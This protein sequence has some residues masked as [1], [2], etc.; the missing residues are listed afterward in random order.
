MRRCCI[1]IA[2][3]VF[4]W[5]SVADAQQNAKVEFLCDND[6]ALA[7]M[8]SDLLQARQDVLRGKSA[9]A[10][11]SARAPHAVR[12]GRL[13][14]LIGTTGVSEELLE[15][16][17]EAKIDVMDTVTAFGLNTLIVQCRDPRQL[18]SLARR[19]DVRVITP[20]PLAR[21]RA[22]LATSQAYTSVHADQAFADFGVDGSGVRVGVLSDS[23]F[24]TRSGTVIIGFLAGCL[25]Q[26]SGDLPASI[27]IIDPGP[28]FDTIDEGNGMAQL[29][30]DLAPG[31]E[32]SFGSA[33]TDYLS[34][35]ENIIALATDSLAPADVLVDDVI[36]FGEPMYQ[37]GPIAIAARTAATVYGVP[38]FSSA[39]NEGDD[40]HEAAFVD[41]NSGADD[42]DFPASGNDLHDFGTAKGLASDTHLEI[43][44]PSGGY[45]YA[46]LHWTEPYGGGLA[47]GPGAA[48]DLDLYL[49]DDTSL[50]LTD[51]GNVVTGSV[52][53]Q[54]TSAA[55]PGGD[56]YELLQYFNLSGSAE[57]VYVVVDHYGGRETDLDLNLVLIVDGTI[58]DSQLVGDRTIYGH[59][60]AENVIAVAANRYDQ[61]TVESFS[62]LGGDLPFWFSDDG[63]TRYATAQTRFKPEITAPDGT[64][65]TF[66]GS[67]DFD[68]TGYPNFFGTS[69]AAPHAAAVA[70]LMLDANS[71]LTPA[72]IYST[73]RST[74]DDIETA[75]E[76]FLSGSGIV[77]ARNAVDAARSVGVT[78][79]DFWSYR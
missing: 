26:T 22:G 78:G 31:C 67:G 54:G 76:D 24:D 68:S 1:A 65:T 79:L 72:Q 15:A 49:V 71:G 58:V 43:S 12:T 69:A 36:Y 63:N 18:D 17:R 42:T 30:Y 40:G 20:E 10:A 28:G 11:F 7:A 52:S 45:L 57:T 16:C 74:A 56:P 19:S 44:V 2:M 46:I 70:A 38:Y 21:T 39:G 55:T 51:P 37:D 3:L 48:V 25:D 59:A 29:I 5:A 62:S 8:T 66:F 14:C 6:P 4:F 64:D 34:F 60:A 33:F 23:F 61:N 27:R 47:A 73:M 53:T 75:G 41:V 35:A 9:L 32:I 50:P 77:N 13:Q